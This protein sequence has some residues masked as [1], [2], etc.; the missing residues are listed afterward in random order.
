MKATETLRKVRFTPWQC[1][2]QETALRAG[3][4]RMHNLDR[5]HSP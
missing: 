3:N 5:G 2:A 1:A 4:G